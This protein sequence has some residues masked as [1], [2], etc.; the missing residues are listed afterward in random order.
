LLQKYLEKVTA[1]ENGL[2]DLRI[3]LRWSMERE[4]V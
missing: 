1:L 2:G 3:T 4:I